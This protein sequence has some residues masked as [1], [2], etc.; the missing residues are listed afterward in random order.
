MA[1]RIRDLMIQ[2]VQGGGCAGPT[3]PQCTCTIATFDDPDMAVR[4]EPMAAP[5]C[6]CT[7]ATMYGAA[8]GVA[9]AAGVEAYC[10]C[11]IATMGVDP[12]PRLPG[13]VTTVTTFTTV[14]T[15]TTV[16]Q[17]GGRGRGDLKSLKEQLRQAL[18]QVERQESTHGQAPER[19]P[20]T[21]EET[22]DLERRLRGAIDELEQHRKNLEQ[23]AAEAPKPRKGGRKGRK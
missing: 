15:V 12:E 19:L 23:P 8:Q 22:L 4:P 13:G 20:G 2:V 3:D 11:T 10:T 7:I 21:V 17:G 5:P 18:E 14:T 1:F 6:T 16:V 9:P